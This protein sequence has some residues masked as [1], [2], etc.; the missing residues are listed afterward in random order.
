MLIALT[1]VIGA[2]VAGSV[3][4]P[5]MLVLPGTTALLVSRRLRI[6]VVASTVVALI[7]TGLGLAL[8]A[9]WAFLPAGPLIV[10]GMFV[11]FLLA[12][13]WSKAG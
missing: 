8:A 5:A 3:L 7:A 10:L 13:A 12:Y 9:R 1:I 4:I 11:Q 6:A 2:R